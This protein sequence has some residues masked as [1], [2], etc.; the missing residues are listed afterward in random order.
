MHASFL[1]TGEISPSLG[2]IFNSL[3]ATCSKSV[4]PLKKEEK[5]GN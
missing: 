4:I 1:N 5:S 2:G 3:A